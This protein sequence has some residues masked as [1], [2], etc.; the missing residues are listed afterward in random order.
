MEL[1]RDPTCAI[2]TL[3]VNDQT[4]SR[5]LNETCVH[6]CPVDPRQIS[7][8]QRTKSRVRQITG[9]N[10]QQLCWRSE[11]QMRR[12]EVSIFCHDNSALRVGKTTKVLI[13]RALA[14]R[15]PQRMDN[16]VAV[17]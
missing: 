7:Q 17:R 5:K 6:E 12:H 15:Q 11:E 4:R 3:P 9:R 2:P 16:L 14:F 13:F 10:L 1:K 8:H